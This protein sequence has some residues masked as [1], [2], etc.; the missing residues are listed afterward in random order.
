MSKMLN[1][2]ARKQRLRRLP[3]NLLGTRAHK[4]GSVASAGGEFSRAASELVASIQ[5][6]FPRNLDPPNSEVEAAG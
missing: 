1:A 6:A 3:G 2:N 5:M 4:R